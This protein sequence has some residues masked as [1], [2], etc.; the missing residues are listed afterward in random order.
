MTRKELIEQIREKKSFLCVGLDTD[1]DKMPKGLKEIVKKEWRM[2]HHSEPIAICYKFI[3]LRIRQLEHELRREAGN[4]T[5]HGLI[6]P[7]C[8]H[9]VKRRQIT[10]KHNRLSAQFAN[11]RTYVTDLYFS[12]DCHNFFHADSFTPRTELTL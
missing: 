6:Q 5:L 11:E 12:I 9:M 4:V 1:L 10:I 2:F 7:S 8:H 3:H